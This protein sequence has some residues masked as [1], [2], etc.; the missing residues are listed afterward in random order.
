M[1]ASL[2]QQQLNVPVAIIQVGGGA[3]SVQNWLPASQGGTA[4]TW[5]TPDATTAGGLYTRLSKVAQLVKSFRAMDI[6]LGFVGTGAYVPWTRPIIRFTIGG[7]Q[8]FFS[9]ISLD[10]GLADT[11]GGWIYQGLVGYAPL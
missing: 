1:F 8:R 11:A 6:P 2:M 7:P 9:T 10:E 5:C 4:A 3:T